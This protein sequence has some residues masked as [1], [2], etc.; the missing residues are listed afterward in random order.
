MSDEKITKDIAIPLGHAE[1]G[2]LLMARVQG[3]EERPT[4][5]LMGELQPLEEGKPIMG[6]VVQLHPEEGQRHMRVETVIEDPFKAEK[7]KARASGSKTFSFP[8]KTY[9][10]N[11]DR[12][13]RR[14][15]EPAD[16]N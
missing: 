3:T 16:I 7:E 5:V 2:N 1:N 12:I 10:D 11:W 6:E 13:F 14:K 8:S 15:S 4:R 9:Q